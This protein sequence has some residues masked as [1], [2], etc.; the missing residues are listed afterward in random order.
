MLLEKSLEPAETERDIAGQAPNAGVGDVDGEG[1]SRRKE[2]CSRSFGVVFI[3]AN[4][5]LFDGP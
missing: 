5:F 2:G 4:D 1:E 3:L